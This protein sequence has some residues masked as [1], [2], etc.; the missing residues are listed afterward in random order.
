MSGTAS[1]PHLGAPLTAREVEVLGLVA[2]GLD[3]EGVG[4]RL[5][6]A[7]HTIRSHMRRIG[8]KLGNGDRAGMVGIAYEAGILAA[9]RRVVPVCVPDE[10]S[11]AMVALA[12]AVLDGRAATPASQSAARAVVRWSRSAQFAQAS[13]RGR[14]S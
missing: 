7:P 5:G 12:R 10:L 13:G 11:L 6:L 3:N 4:E 8:R 9:G 2:E 14:A 1:M